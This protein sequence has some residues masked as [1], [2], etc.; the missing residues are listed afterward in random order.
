MKAIVAIKRVVDPNIEVRVTPDGMGVATANL[1]STMNPYDEN[2]LEEAVRL[3]E[4]AIVTEV[5]AVSIGSK[6]AEEMLRGALAQG[7]T[8]AVHVESAEPLD[9]LAVAKVLAAICEREDP[10]LVLLGR[11]A[12]DDECGAVGA[13]LASLLNWDQ[14]IC[15]S[16]IHI[17]DRI[18]TVRQ[19]ADSGTV[20][21][22]ME[23]PAVV[24][25]DFCLNTPRTPG[26]AS[27]VA[28]KRAKVEKIT[29]ASLGKDLRP[30]HKIVHMEQPDAG[31]GGVILETVEGLL[32]KLKMEAG[33]M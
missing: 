21:V 26:F 20:T 3:K 14:G 17:A 32:E 27:I 31:R 9:S 6:A 22:E 18:V 19:S 11:Q 8:R 15:A 7:A 4:Q 23:L 28:A 33:F 30:R 10:A 29:A 16:K 13:M 12:V 2:A 24:T 1:K 25:A 5:V